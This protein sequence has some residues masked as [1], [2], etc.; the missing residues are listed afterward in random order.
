MDRIER[1]TLAARLAV[2]LN[3]VSYAAGYA[4]ATAADQLFRLV[5]DAIH[6]EWGD[7]DDA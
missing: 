6:I 4:I 7:D 2:A 1:T 3:A 5:D